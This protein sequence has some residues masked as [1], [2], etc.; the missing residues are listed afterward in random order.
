[1][2]EIIHAVSKAFQLEFEPD[3]LK[4]TQITIT[5]NVNHVTSK[6]GKADQARW[7]MSVIPDTQRHRVGGLQFKPSLNKKLVRPHLDQ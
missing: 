6:K 5:I 3:L 2:E 7:L 4:A 1:M